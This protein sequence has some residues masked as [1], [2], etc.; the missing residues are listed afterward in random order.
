[1]TTKIAE[2]Q[3]D[4][5][6]QNKMLPV[7]IRMLVG[8]TVFFFV[9][10]FLQLFYLHSKID[11]SPQ[12]TLE[13]VRGPDRSE[14]SEAPFLTQQWQTVATLEKHTLDQRYHQANVL[15]MSR[16][17]TRYLAFVTG[18]ILCMVGA[19]FILGKLR[20]DQ[21]EISG[22][23]DLGEGSLK[24]SSPGV[25]LATLGVILMLTSLLTHHEISV[26]DGPAYLH[27]PLQSPTSLNIPGPSSLEEGS[28]GEEVAEE[29]AIGSLLDEL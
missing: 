8:L 20:E 24:T 16:I 23:S 27:I 6:W 12:I 9:A 28:D 7:M 11:K 22:K 1:M 15:L 17:W 29:D 3:E 21:T 4:R 19:S 18:M 25:L 13:Q 14:G 5:K 2:K 10:S 26:T